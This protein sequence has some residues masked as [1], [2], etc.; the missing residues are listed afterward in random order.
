M[1]ALQALREIAIDPKNVLIET[2]YEHEAELVRYLETHALW[3][4]LSRPSE[5]RE[6]WSLP[7]QDLGGLANHGNG[8]GRGSPGCDGEPSAP[9]V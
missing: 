2:V 7:R 4:W 3:L 1:L 9:P 8:I 6:L 5:A